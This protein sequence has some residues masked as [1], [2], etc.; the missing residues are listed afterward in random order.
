MDDVAIGLQVAPTF[1]ATV[2]DTNG[3]FSLFKM[4]TA[5][6]SCN[7][8]THN[9]KGRQIDQLHIPTQSCYAIGRELTGSDASCDEV[10]VR[11]SRNVPRAK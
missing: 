11:G 5:I 8:T 1:D 4:A 2:D 9:V 6:E 10:I 3:T 7:N